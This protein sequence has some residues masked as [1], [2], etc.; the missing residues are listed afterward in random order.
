M[1]VVLDASAALEIFLN[2]QDT[3]KFN[4]II[5]QDDLILAPDTFPSEITN[6]LWKYANY[7][8][9]DF[10]KCET[11]I[12]YCIELIDDFVDTKEICHEV[13]AESIKSKH[14]SYDIFYLIVARRNNSTL[15]SKDKKLIQIAKSLGI[16]V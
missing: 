16:N 6:V 4:K 14:S 3:D 9:F 11:G 7:S 1:T 2:K 8:D 5:A 13:F 12:S 10:E 15:L